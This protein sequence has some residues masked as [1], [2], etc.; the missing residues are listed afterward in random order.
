MVE[1]TMEARCAR[2]RVGGERLNHSSNVADD[3]N[4]AAI[5]FTNLS[6]PRA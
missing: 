6:E 1:E 2:F 4:V 5:P 3:L